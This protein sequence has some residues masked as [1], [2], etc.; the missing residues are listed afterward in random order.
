MMNPRSVRLRLI[1]WYAGLLT[2]VFLVFGVA[3]YQVLRGYLENSL[4]Q[5][6]I[7]GRR[8]NSQA[9]TPALRRLPLGQAKSPAVLKK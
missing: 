5:A 4:A 1:I 9:M 3:L 8:L 2:G 6:L 7:R